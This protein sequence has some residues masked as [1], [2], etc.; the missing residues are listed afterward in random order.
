VVK[1]NQFVAFYLKINPAV[2]EFVNEKVY[3]SLIKV[4]REIVN[5]SVV[6]LRAGTSLAKKEINVS[7]MYFNQSE[8][9]LDFL[10]NIN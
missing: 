1:L 4:G 9:Y 2:L 5:N 8:F 7:Q 6:S 10:K 3:F